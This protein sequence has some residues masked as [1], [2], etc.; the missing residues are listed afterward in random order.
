MNILEIEGELANI[1]PPCK[2]DARQLS[3]AG[4]E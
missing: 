3:G 4:A 2:W 1:D